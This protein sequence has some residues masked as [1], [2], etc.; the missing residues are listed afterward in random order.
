MKR[1]LL[2][3]MAVLFSSASAL[4]ADVPMGYPGPQVYRAAPIA[5]WNG[6]YIG[7]QG[8]YARA[9]SDGVPGHIDGGLGGGQVGCNWQT[10]PS[11]VWGLEGDLLWSGIKDGDPAIAE[12]KADWLGSVRL[13]GGLS[14]ST[15]LLYATGGVGFG[16][17][18]VTGLGFEDSNTH[19][20]WVAGGGLEWMIA[21][22]WTGKIEYLHY[23]FGKKTYFGVL[24]VD[25]NVDAIKIGLNYKFGY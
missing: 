16:H 17:G 7:I 10:D 22:N 20:G 14:S 6:C 24:P 19:T 13:R 8:G 25:Y 11:W 21:A 15:A 3:G 4:A 12:L 2:A 18:V 5:T 1:F 9:T 23:D